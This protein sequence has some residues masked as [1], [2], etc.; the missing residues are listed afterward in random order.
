MTKLDTDV[1]IKY[2]KNGN[3]KA[4]VTPYDKDKIINSKIKDK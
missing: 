3:I 4:I 2:D 1:F